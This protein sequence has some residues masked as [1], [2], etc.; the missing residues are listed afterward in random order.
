MS[1]GEIIKILENRL[2]FC[3]QQRQAAHNCGDLVAVQNFD[4]EINTTTSSLNQIR[5][6]GS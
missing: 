4:E 5:S 1:I 6:I 2:T 3:T